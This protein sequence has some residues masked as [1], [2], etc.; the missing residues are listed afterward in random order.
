[1]DIGVLGLQGAVS[2]HVDAFTRALAARKVN[3]RAYAIRRRD[4]LAK[5]DALALP[6]G[7]S[8]TIS[9]LLR[10]FDMH[11]ALV[12]RI[13]NE[14]FPVLGTCA[15]LILLASEGDRQVADTE[16]RLLGVMDMATNR[17]A[18]GR[19]RESFEA[20]VDLAGIGPFHA[21]FIRA[22]AITRTWGRARAIATLPLDEPLPG[23]G[24]APII[25]AE[26]G[27]RLALAFHPE[28][29]DDVRVHA[30]FIERVETWKKR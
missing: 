25:A 24:R 15:G 14:D 20:D 17:N 16:T 8:T 2:E 3:G 21:V 30:A 4:D 9:K 18:F 1:M 6:G 28:L 22:P 26:Q 10:Q 11:D 19:Q 29:T 12:A 13:A 5:V 23:V 7:E 27:N